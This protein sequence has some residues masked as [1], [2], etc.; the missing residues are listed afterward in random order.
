[1]TRARHRPSRIPTH[2]R[3]RKLRDQF[4]QIGVDSFLVTFQPHLRY[5]SG[6]SGSA[7]AGLVSAD[8]AVLLTDGRYADQVRGEVAGWK[9]AVCR[10]GFLDELGRRRLLWPGERV[11]FDGNTVTYAQYRLF[12][13]TFPGVTFRP[14]VDCVEKI[15]VVKDEEEIANIRKAVSITDRVFSDVLGLIRPGIRE[16]DIAAEISYR[17]LKYGAE[18]DAFETI[19]ASGERGALPH[20]R[21]SMKKIARREM[22]TLDFGCVVLGYHSDMTRTV[23]VGRPVPEA[24]KI[25]RT[26]LDAQSR[27][28]EAAKGGIR[29]GDL[30]AVARSA[31]RKEGYDR[32]F[33]HSLGHGLGLQIHEP[34][35]ISVLSK[36]VLQ[37]GNVVTIEPGIYVAGLGGVRIEDDVVIRADG[38][39]VLNRSAKELIVL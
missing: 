12:K 36:S 21:A 18:G 38:C 6:F 32:Y 7:G 24:A 15:A 4:A 10:D 37:P 34:P 26:V 31:I 13:K 33:R 30:D 1:M 20:G 27:A 35:R 17:H 39:E 29:T 5:L 14:R 25:Y 8:S 16:L 19:V 23:A 2:R 28:V 22:V 9:V 11:G 3:L